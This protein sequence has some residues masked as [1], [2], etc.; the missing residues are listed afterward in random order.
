MKPEIKERIEMINRGEVP[1]GYKKTKVGIIP[2]NWEIRRLGSLGKSIIGLTYSPSDICNDNTGTLVLRSSNIEGNRLVYNDNV[3][4]KKNIPNKLLVEIGDILVCVRNG[5]RALIG[6]NAYISEQH[7]GHSFGA[8]M[9]V[10]RSKNSRFIFQLLQ[11]YHFKKQIFANLGATINQI[12]TKDLSAFI[13]AMPPLAEQQK[14][15]SILSTWDKA[16]E[17]K[18]RLIEQKKEQKKGLMQNLLF[19]KILW[20]DNVSRDRKK[21]QTRIKII[22]NGEVPVGYKKTKAGIIPMHWNSLKAEDLFKNH[23]N[24][25]HD[26]NLEVLSATQDRGIIPRSELDID[27]KYDKESLGTYKKVES[28]NFVISL[29]SF[30][31]GIEYSEYEGLVSPAYTVIKNKIDMDKG[32]YKYYLKTENFI[33]RLNSVIYGIRDGKQI[34]FSDFSQLYLVYPPV[35]EQ[36]NIAGIINYSNTEI[37]LLEQE[38]DLLRQQKKGLMQLLLTGKVRV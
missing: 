15:A 19:G 38:L 36:K 26:G 5:S 8:F 20:N 13:F 33:R 17:L 23:T 27:I 6:K 22:K 21:I 32:Y 24:K 9:S 1:E 7:L 34:G 25:K 28:G 4:V 11:T 35:T 37:N 18:E 10:Y 14:I 29:R 2:E 3:Y 31:G 12:T 30:Q 16:I